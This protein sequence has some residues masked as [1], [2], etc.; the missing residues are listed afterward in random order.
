MESG[1]RVLVIGGGP[2]GISAAYHLRRLGHD[3]E[4]RDSGSEVGG[5]MRYGIPAYR[6]PRE[7][8]TGEVDRIAAMGVRITLGHTVSDLAR[9]RAREVLM[10]YSS[11]SAPIC[12]SA[13]TFRHTIPPA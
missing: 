13:W 6:L 1:H 5:M 4:I 10:P 9:E 3:V 2:S 12:P 11:R 8:L 7:V